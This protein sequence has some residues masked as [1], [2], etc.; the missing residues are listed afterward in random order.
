MVC[1]SSYM[2]FLC[3]WFLFIV[4]TAMGTIWAVAQESDTSRELERIDIEAP[5]PR[6]VTAPAARSDRGS[7]SD[8]LPPPESPSPWD[9]ERA[10]EIP[11]SIVPS[12]L[13]L[14]EGK[15]QIS[16]AAASLPAQ[17]Q[18]V[19]AQDIRELNTW[20]DYATWFARVAGV[21]AINYGQGQIGTAVSMRGFTSSTGQEVAVFVDG[22]P[23]NLPSGVA[24]NGR[25]ELSWLTPEVI[26]KI[27]IIKGPVSAMY[28]NYALAGVLN[29]V[30]KK[31]EPAPAITSSGGSFNN[32]RLLGVLSNEA[33][34][35]T[36]Y[37]A[38]Q[39]YTIDGYRDNSQLSQWS[40]F[41]KVSY[42]LWGG[43]LSLR[44]NYYRSDWGAPGYWPIDWVKSGLIERTR[45]FNTSDGGY[46]RRYELVMNYAPSCGERGLYTTL[47]VGNYRGTRYASF[48]PIPP[49][50]F[51]RQ[52]DRV[53]WGGRVY[54]NLVFGDVA[55]LTIGGETRQDSGEAQQFNTVN[56]RRTTTRYDYDLR[57]SNCG[58]FLQ[59]QI[60]PVEQLKIV[61]GVRWDYFL[62][63]IDN[64]I[65]PRNSGTGVCA[66][67]SPKVGFVM[68]PTK[69]INIFGNLATGFR[70]PSNLEM[71]P[72]S[73]SADKDFS[74]E[75]AAVQT[76]DV[77]CNVAL[78][79]NLF[80]AA[81]YYHTYMQREIRM[82]NN[83]P[84]VVGDTVRKG[85]ELE[86]RFYPADSE[87][88][89]VFGSYAW[90]DA[91]VIDPTVPGQILVQDISEHNIKG[92]VTMRRRF[93]FTGEL[94]ADLYYQYTS[95]APYYRFAG[96]AAERATP[97]FGPDFDVYNLKLTYTGTGWSSFFSARCKPR[98]FSAD[99]TWVSNDLLVY[100]PQ[101]QWEFAAGLTY[102]F[103]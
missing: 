42:P 60:K 62:Q 51:C 75:P 6:P 78:F 99:Y 8:R 89:S 24:V 101:P 53:Y 32:F 96:T 41:N 12:T 84:V 65:L 76:Y 46:Q 22:V 80:L 56:R 49:S 58:I 28:G 57:L 44:Y 33:W 1:K 27:E 79:G 18:A 94:T 77:G 7:E 93:G 11:S 102:S 64:L 61:G 92:G 86:A 26:E 90:V 36:P 45:A 37:L 83:N 67:R 71:S 95:G 4:V 39:Y 88:F 73:A 70:S 50:Q 68:T 25:V 74:L 16:L 19:T 47:F 103:W 82:V 98:E 81:D 54:Y 10:S 30:T 17:T 9:G 48:L 59:G 31:S 69:N 43:T 35:P 23:Q 55:S 100:D 15:S 29:I 87:D 5:E 34:T 3:S 20:G 2:R 52:D 21:K 40:P 38:H 97:V 72:Y 14:V 13:S 66:I 85:Y 63:D 91:R